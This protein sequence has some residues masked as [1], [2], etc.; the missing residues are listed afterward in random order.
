MAALIDVFLDRGKDA[1]PSGCPGCGEIVREYAPSDEDNYECWGFV[2]GCE[3]LNEAPDRSLTI[4]E[5]CPD[6]MDRCM[7]MMIFHTEK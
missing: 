4:N 3:L 1:F 5:R 2:C 7:E 6:A